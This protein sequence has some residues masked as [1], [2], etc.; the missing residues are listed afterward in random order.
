MSQV[1]TAT[2]RD[3]VLKPDQEM[4]LSSGTKV[5]LAVERCEE[6]DRRRT[7]ASDELDQLCDEFPIDSQGKRRTRD[8]LHERH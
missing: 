2:V 8:Q 4:G 6:V 5:R 7:L 3:G 1:I